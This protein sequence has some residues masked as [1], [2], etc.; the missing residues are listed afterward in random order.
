[1]QVE[2]L[3]KSLNRY[4]LST[5]PL[6]D[7][8]SNLGQMVPPGLAHQPQGG[9]LMSAHLVEVEDGR[10]GKAA[11]TAKDSENRAWVGNFPAWNI[12]M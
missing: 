9:D 3:V 6:L 11:N 10:S 5:G 12:K 1:M 4:E 7:R 8:L 2:E